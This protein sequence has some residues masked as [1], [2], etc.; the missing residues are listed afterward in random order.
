VN[1]RN[2]LS[3]LGLAPLVAAVPVASKPVR[4]IACLKRP[5]G[6]VVK[7][8]FLGGDIKAAQNKAVEWLERTICEGD[9]IMI[10][11]PGMDYIWPG[12]AR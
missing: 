11:N 7:R 9:E 2:F 12:K 3:W 8:S 10:T 6:A 4:R 5:D 1:R